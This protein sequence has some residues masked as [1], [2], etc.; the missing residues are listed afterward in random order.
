MTFFL[1]S[2]PTSSPMPVSRHLL[3]QLFVCLLFG[4]T[5]QVVQAA[6]PTC[7]SSDL[8]TF[9][10]AFATDPELQLAFS[11]SPLVEQRL[12]YDDFGR[13][14][15]TRHKLTG[16]NRH[17]LALLDPK[18]QA[19]SGLQTFWEDHTLVVH[20]PQ[21]DVVQAFVFERSAC[22]QLTRIEQWSMD[23][24]LDQQAPADETALQRQSR[25]A[26]LFLAYGGRE[27]YPLTV[28]FFE[29]GQR[30]LVD[31]ARHGSAKAAVQAVS[32]GYSGM[33]PELKPG[34]AEELLL[35]YAQADADAAVMLSMYYCD[36][37][38]DGSFE[39]CV[40]PG[41]AE[42][43]VLQAL[44]KLDSGMLYDILADALSSG[45]WGTTDKARAL[46]CYKEA[47]Q[48]DHLS[49][50][51]TLTRLTA[52]GLPAQEAQCLEASPKASG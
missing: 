17:L 23:G 27:Q 30:I 28:Y 13:V 4:T 43:T 24:L 16:D 26:D 38:G 6:A 46:A 12:V 5:A 50:L 32:L 49:A 45:R 37:K 39:S 2:L 18:A 21:G 14:A 33:A 7:P 1:P 22:W 52:E 34:E 44:H 3:R 47:I 48:R 10:R 8:P 25:K 51:G 19:R 9:V 40:N 31:A 42:A 15:T 35:P 11:D 20:D 41:K 36:P 29:L